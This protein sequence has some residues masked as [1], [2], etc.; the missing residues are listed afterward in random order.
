[1]QVLVGCV[2]H[3]CF[4]VTTDVCCTGAHENATNLP[5][6]LQRAPI[7]WEVWA[8]GSVHGWMSVI[9]AILWDVNGYYRCTVLTR[10]SRGM[11]VEGVGS[12]RR[13]IRQRYYIELKRCFSLHSHWG[14][15][16]LP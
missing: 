7:W 4:G 6:L 15:N 11:Q 5:S 14:P 9:H 3:G 12:W 1:M 2:K 8:S 13:E 10:F 16:F